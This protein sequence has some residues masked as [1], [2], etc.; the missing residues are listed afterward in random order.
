M[1]GTLDFS[2]INED[3]IKICFDLIN[4]NPKNVDAW[5]KLTQIY[6]KNQDFKMAEMC[7]NTAF[8]CDE[9]KNIR[10]LSMKAFYHLKVGEFNEAKEIYLYL[11]NIAKN[12]LNNNSQKDN[13]YT[14]FVNKIRIWKFNLSEIEFYLGNEI[15]GFELYEYRTK[16]L[17][18]DFIDEADII[19][20][21]NIKELT[22]NEFREKEFKKIIVLSEQGYG[23]QIMI[24]RYLKSLK[25]LGFI[26]TY[27]CNKSLIDLFRSYLNFKN[28][29]IVKKI[30]KQD[31]KESDRIVWS[32]SLPY[33][34]YK[35]NKKNCKILES[36]KISP[37][38]DLD[39]NENKTIN[40][41]ICW[42]GNPKNIRDK[43][44]SIELKLFEHLFKKNC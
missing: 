18:K 6:V 5:V 42:K 39:F 29:K 14:H 43:E 44:R 12:I 23:D 32:M 13:N 9:N 38:M 1:D 25:E 35:K 7:I 4:I 21:S 26:V 16:K 37:Q 24:S 10:M 2:T 8:Q 22:F 27:V 36:L 3:Q 34:F 31:I 15:S 17:E 19:A 33:F 11:I 40:I 30:S 20:L 41:G 28:L